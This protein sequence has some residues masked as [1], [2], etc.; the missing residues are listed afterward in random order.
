VVL[1]EPVPAWLEVIRLGLSLNQGFASRVTIFPN[2]VYPDPGNYTLHIP[3]PNKNEHLYLGMSSMHG[4][5]GMIKGYSNERIIPYG[6][7]RANVYKHV[8]GAIRVD[9]VVDGGDKTICLVKADVEGY[10]PQALST[11][12]KLIHS[13]SVPVIQ[14]E[15]TKSS[16]VNQTCSAVNVLK[17]LHT[18]GYEFRI[19]HHSLVDHILLPPLGEWRRANAMNMLPTFPSPKASAEAKRRGWSDMRAAYEFDF[20]TFSTNLFAVKTGKGKSRLGKGK[21]WPKLTCRK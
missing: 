3:I 9:D 12:Q 7:I 4:A 17:H 18:L 5:T 20:N 15:L 16:N 13:K 14:L 6:T 10:E 1:F 2:V 11:A 8:A 19:A 21:R